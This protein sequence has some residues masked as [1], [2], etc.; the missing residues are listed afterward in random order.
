M[1]GEGNWPMGAHPFGVFR[2]NA[3]ALAIDPAVA[4]AEHY[5]V[6]ADYPG[7]PTASPPLN[8]EYRR[9]GVL[10]HGSARR[11]TGVWDNLTGQADGRKGKAWGGHSCL[12]RAFFGQRDLPDYPAWRAPPSVSM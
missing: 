8:R 9:E 10:C 11:K 7:A 2:P 4:D 12:P 5:A 6:L 3:E 1:L